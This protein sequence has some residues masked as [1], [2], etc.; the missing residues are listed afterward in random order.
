MPL[1]NWQRRA[2]DGA[3]ATFHSDIPNPKK[4][5]ASAFPGAG[6]TFFALS[7]VKEVMK[8]QPDHF[9]IIL[10]PTIEIK[11]NWG[12][13]AETK[14]SIKTCWDNNVKID[15]KTRR[16]HLSPNYKGMVM[17]YQGLATMCS[18]EE[19][20]NIMSSFLAAKKVLLILDECHHLSESNSWG[21][22][23][24]DMFL[25][26]FNVFAL[27]L[28]GTPFR[29]DKK[30]IPFLP[31]KEVEPGIIEYVPNVVVTY[32]EGIQDGYLRRIC[33][34][35]Q[36]GTIQ[37]PTSNDEV[38]AAD[39]RD[40]IHKKWEPA[41]LRG[42]LQ[43]GNNHTFLETLLKKGIKRLNKTRRKF[44][45]AQGLVIAQ[46]RQHAGKIR[47][48][49]ETR[50]CNVEL[51]VSERGSGN[52]DK[53]QRLI[54]KFREN[55]NGKY[56]WIIAVDMISEGVDIPN[57]CTI[58]YAT[59]KT[60]VMYFCQGTGRGIRTSSEMPECTVAHIF[61]PED[62]RLVKIVQTLMKDLPPVTMDAVDS[63]SS[64][65]EPHEITDVSVPPDIDMDLDT[66]Y[67]SNTDTGAA[68]SSVATE[69]NAFNYET[70]YERALNPEY[71]EQARNML[72]FGLRDFE[73]FEKCYAFVMEQRGQPSQESSLATIG[74]DPQHVL[75][76]DKKRELQGKI[77]NHIKRICGRLHI[78]QKDY[79][80]FIAI[81][82]NVWK[83]NA[84][85]RH[86]SE[87]PNKYTYHSMPGLNEMTPNEL[88]T[89]YNKH[90]RRFILEWAES[91]LKKN[92]HDD[93]KNARDDNMDI[94]TM[95]KR[96][97]TH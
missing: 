35:T 74:H 71:E 66:Q 59:N 44:P 34:I 67:D 30:R 58:V 70:A 39:F 60:T 31:Y 81:C 69:S 64:D 57:V 68:G 15:T 78:G 6:K 96:Q 10:V 29:T 19:K 27:S 86:R 92:A 42:A 9:L 54:K 37:I 21:K 13:K 3:L 48:Y 61:L 20:K 2:L 23:L 5:M 11:R 28:S 41:R 26:H 32:K 84:V 51:V 36:N 4:F 33:A 90:N 49:M 18:S 12:T 7:F 80:R 14:F 53:N 85:H 97:K 38:F 82:T 25:N 1:R 89:M 79:G 46:N 62:P 95:F 8:Q 87:G 50:G 22:T 43:F 75:E 52:G 93:N 88:R 83:W 17:T 94:R 73:T 40:H 63:S 76:R 55:V 45:R 47:E 16:V 24:E 72:S 91:K 56:E 77:N 65:E